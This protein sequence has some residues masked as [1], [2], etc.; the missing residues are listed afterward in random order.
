MHAYDNP[1]FV[2]DMVR[3]AAVRLKANPRVTWFKVRSSN[4]SIEQEVESESC[5][6][7]VFLAILSAENQ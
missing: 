1:V 5:A 7:E 4:C 6:S 2:E 3:N